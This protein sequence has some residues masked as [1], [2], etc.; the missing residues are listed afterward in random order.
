MNEVRRFQR[1]TRSYTYAWKYSKHLALFNRN[2]SA[3][4][5]LNVPFVLLMNNAR[6]NSILC[7]G[8]CCWITYD[9]LR[10]PGRFHHSRNL[11]G[12]AMSFI[13]PNFSLLVIPI[14]SLKKFPPWLCKK[15][16]FFNDISLANSRNFGNGVMKLPEEQREERIMIQWYNAL[17][18]PKKLSEQSNR[19]TILEEKFSMK[20]FE[21][22]E[23]FRVQN[24][25][26]FVWK[27]YIS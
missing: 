19:C 14:I 11:L 1:N 24:R 3:G 17:I 9:P 13:E 25:T 22:I 7:F 8:S 4:N 12:F 10:F 26:A 6:I 27:I 5:V 2:N 18:K 21:N 20:V 23:I 16:I 15:C